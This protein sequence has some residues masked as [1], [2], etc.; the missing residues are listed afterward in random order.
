MNAVIEVPK[1][2]GESSRKKPQ[3]G[4]GGNL[5]FVFQRKLKSFRQMSKN[6]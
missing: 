1:L 2:Y 4:S 6:E 5:K 3:D